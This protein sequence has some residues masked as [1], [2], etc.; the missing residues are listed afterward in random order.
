MDSIEELIQRIKNGEVDLFEKIVGLYQQQLFKYCFHM[1]GN[2]H[3][4]EDVVQEVFLKTYEK[5]LSYK[6]GISF[7]AWI[8]KITYNQCINIIRRKKL[9]QFIP[10]MEEIKYLE[11][12]L[13]MSFIKDELSEELT[14]GLS[15]LKSEE[16][17]III[18]RTLDEKSY[19]EISVILD[20]SAVAA[21]KKYERAKQKLKK[22]LILKIGGVK[23]GG[24]AVEG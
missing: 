16:K 15:K 23:D 20:I 4:A 22:N 1:L 7:S 11:E 8:Y 3:E 12:D 18:F 6:A 10:F 19:E 14:K 9:L 5:L 17:S 21:R 2:I 13:N 24:F